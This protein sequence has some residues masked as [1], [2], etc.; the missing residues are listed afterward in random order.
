MVAL[1]K[2]PERLRVGLDAV[3]AGDYQHR[4]V[5]NAKRALSLG[6]EVHVARGIQEGQAPLPQR[7]DRL[8]GEDGDA[9]LPLQSMGIEEAVAVI[10]PSQ[11]FQFS[12]EV[13]HGLAQRGLARVHM[14]QDAQHHILFVSHVR[15]LPDFP[16]RINAKVEHIN[17][18]M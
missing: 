16:E 13:Q 1:Q 11:L 5:E 18:V 12:R 2:L 15:I 3:G 4:A 9:A 17:G 7:Q 14:R 10:D 8:L 6:G